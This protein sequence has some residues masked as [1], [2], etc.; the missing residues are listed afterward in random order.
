MSE[1]YAHSETTIRVAPDQLRAFSEEV[2]ARCGFPREEA[3]TL[4]D[5][6]VQADLRGV[7]SHGTMR[8]PMYARRARAGG[9]RLPTQP[10]ISETGPASAA[11]DGRHG[12]GQ[13]LALRAMELAVAKAKATGCGVVTV[14]NSNHFGAAAYYT[15][16]AVR[17][18]CIGIAMT[19]ASP[20]L[21]PTGGA[22]RLLG[23]NPWSIAAPTGG[24]FPLVMDMA[25]S[26][27]AVG[28]IRMRMAKGE[29]LPPG[30]ARDRDGRPTTD[31]A[32]ALDGFLEFIGG[33]K[34][35]A[36]TLMI[37]V[38][39]GVLSGAEFGPRTKGPFEFDAPSGIGH[40][41]M[42]IDIQRFMPMDSF[43][44]RIDDLIALMH[45]CRRAPDAD[46]V[47]VPGELEHR[48]FVDRSARG[49]PVVAGVRKDLRRLAEEVG[50]AIPDWLQ[51]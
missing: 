2:L 20:R 24:P 13:V 32:A 11:I 9:I 46:E 36:L 42:A 33:Y 25:T 30:W 6:L 50:A 1:L 29:P 5:T 49:I 31:P 8:L 51:A 12:C 17:H 15:L 44:Q 14:R 39:A 41:L 40:L 18:G 4:A 34:G 16:Y 47:L 43:L 38:L 37:D 3:A 19:N 23:N 27:V 26:V 35:Y 48:Q 28:K 45:A 21:A 22:E 10:V 7:E